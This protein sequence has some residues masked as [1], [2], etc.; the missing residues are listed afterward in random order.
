MEWIWLEVCVVFMINLFMWG[1]ILILPPIVIIR[2]E[3]KLFKL[4]PLGM[5]FL[6]IILITGKYNTKAV[7]KHELEHVR[8]HRIFSPVGLAIFILFHYS[9]LYYKHRSFSLVYKNSIL[10]KW[11]NE[12]MYSPGELPRYILYIDR[13]SHP[14]V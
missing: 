13:I 6:N 5:T 8:Q 4:H 1:V 7:L 3:I 2:D 10:E 12:K 14:K 11:A 9:Y